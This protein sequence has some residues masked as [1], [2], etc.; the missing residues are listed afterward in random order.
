MIKV[1]P[2]NVIEKVL[3]INIENWFVIAIANCEHNVMAK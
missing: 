1:I 3:N 2:Q